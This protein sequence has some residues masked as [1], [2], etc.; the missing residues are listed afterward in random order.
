MLEKSMSS[1]IT[2]NSSCG[3]SACQ[4]VGCRGCQCL[5][6]WLVGWSSSGAPTLVIRHHSLIISG[7]G[8]TH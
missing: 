6:G 1:V 3:P 5:V 8:T 2:I 7:F 4:I